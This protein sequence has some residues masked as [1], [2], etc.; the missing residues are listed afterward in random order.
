M[1]LF[2]NFETKQS[3]YSGYELDGDEYE[4]VCES[5]IENPKISYYDLQNESKKRI[6]D[7]DLRASTIKYRT[8]NSNSVS[9]TIGHNSKNEVEKIVQNLN[10]FPKRPRLLSS[11]PVAMEDPSWV[12]IYTN[13]ICANFGI[14]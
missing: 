7:V 14:L 10:Y 2:R 9:H 12:K 5:S 11:N 13:N 1:V 8:Q 4:N 3:N 6:I